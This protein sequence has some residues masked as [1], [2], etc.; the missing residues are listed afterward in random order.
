MKGGGDH[1]KKFRRFAPNRCPR[2]LR[3]TGAPT[4][5]FVPALLIRFNDI[6]WNILYA[7]EQTGLFFASVKIAVEL[8]P[9]KEASEELRSGQHSDRASGLPARACDDAVPAAVGNHDGRPHRGGH[10]NAVRV[11]STRSV[12]HHRRSGDLARVGDGAVSC[13]PLFR[14]SQRSYCNYAWFPALRFR[15]S[16]SVSVKPCPYCRSVNAIAVCAI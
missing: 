9:G 13:R 2:L 8:A 15:S 16:V 7:T 12:G 10:S 6:T 11:P 3:P 4:L 1:Q 5:K 14:Q